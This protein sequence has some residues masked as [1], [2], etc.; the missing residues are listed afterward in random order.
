MHYRSRYTIDIWYAEARGCAEGC[1]A[2]RGGIAILQRS[3]YR[4]CEVSI[5][6]IPLAGDENGRI[7]HPKCSRWRAGHCASRVCNDDVEGMS[8]Y[9]LRR[10]ERDC[11]Y[12]G[13]PRDS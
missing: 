8:P 7:H 11:D 4:G 1:I 13:I 12:S 6:E 10:R 9:D 2:L 3:P 5:K